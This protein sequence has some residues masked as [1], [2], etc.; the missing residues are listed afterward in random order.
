[1]NLGL[2]Y[3]NEINVDLIKQLE[4]FFT[5]SLINKK[6]KSKEKKTYIKL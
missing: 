2:P 1:M 5:K 4:I 3:L 6:V